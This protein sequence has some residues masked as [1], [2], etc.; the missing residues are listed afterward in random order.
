MTPRRWLGLAAAAAML[1]GA[2]AAAPALAQSKKTTKPRSQVEDVPGEYIQLETLWVPVLN[3][4]GRPTYL[5]LVVRLWPGGTTRYDAC[6]QTPWVHEALLIHFSDSPL[7]RKTY[8]DDK[9]LNRQVNDV[10]DRVAGSNVYRKA[11]AFRQFVT[12]DEDSSILSATCK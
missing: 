12:P 7:D 11:E 8:D 2:A 3:A 9:A 10:V 5:G 4:A 1:A 6:L